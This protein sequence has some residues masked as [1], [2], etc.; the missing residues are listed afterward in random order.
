MS[1]RLWD[2]AAVAVVSEGRRFPAVVSLG[3]GD[4]TVQVLFDFMLIGGLMVFEFVSTRVNI[5]RQFR[6]Q[7]VWV[8]WPV[9]YATCMAIWLLGISTA[10]KAFIYFQF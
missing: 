5:A 2:R 6:L 10:A 1:T 9:Y 3:P 7:P 4:P 8:R